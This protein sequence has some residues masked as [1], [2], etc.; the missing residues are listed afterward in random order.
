MSEMENKPL[1]PPDMEGQSRETEKS[2]VGGPPAGAVEKPN[3]PVETSGKTI[4]GFKENVFYLGVVSL[5]NDVASEIIY[6][7]AP[8]FLQTVLGAAYAV[9]IG[10]IEGIA[11]GTASLMKLLSGWYSDKVMR[12]KVFVI[13]GYTF[14]VLMR[15]LIGFAHFIRI[16]WYVLAVRFSDR[17]GK[18]IRTAPRDALIANSITEKER[19]KSFGFHRAMDHLGA[20]LG[21]LIA[22]G[23]VSLFGIKEWS[24]LWWIF[25]F[26]FIPGFMSLY[27]V[28][29]KVSDTGTKARVK[30]TEAGESKSTA[31][32]TLQGFDSRFKFFLLILALFTL[33]NSTDVFLILRVANIEEIGFKVTLVWAVFHIIK[34]AFSTPAGL[35]SDYVGRKGVIVAGWLV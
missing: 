20:V 25:L 4:L 17:I 22:F 23:L 24:S 12:K 13:V 29:K 1:E 2:E 26:A 3:K 33:G 6:P 31:R 34:A 8:L 28:V 5:L 15:P 27:F 10:V 30:E 35:I 18:G 32:L 11:E 19:G 7:L 21:A 16:W 14:S 9:F